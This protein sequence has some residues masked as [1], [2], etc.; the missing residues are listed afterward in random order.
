MANKCSYPY[1][2]NQKCQKSSGLVCVSPNS[3]IEIIF[4]VMERLWR[5]K[6]GMTDKHSSLFD[7]FTL[8]V[9]SVIR[10]IKQLARI[11][12]STSWSRPIVQFSEWSQ[13]RHIDALWTD[14]VFLELAMSEAKPYYEHIHGSQNKSFYFVLRFLPGLECELLL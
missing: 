1:A 7:V 11:G 6:R 3:I 10:R 4:F 12:V 2:V 14:F 13:C 5:H 8:V 9:L